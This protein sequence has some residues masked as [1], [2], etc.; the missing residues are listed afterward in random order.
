MKENFRGVTLATLGY[1]DI[2]P[3]TDFVRNLAVM[4]AILGQLFLTVFIARLIGLQ[5]F[6]P[7]LR[8]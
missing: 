2:T 8:K 7:L 3:V 6:K 1:W 4:E 5:L